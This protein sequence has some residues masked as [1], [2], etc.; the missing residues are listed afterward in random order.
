MTRF[1]RRSP[2][3]VLPGVSADAWRKFAAALETRSVSAVSSTGGLGAYEIHPRRLVEL[4]KADNLRY[5]G[6]SGRVQVCDFIAP[7][8]RERFLADPQLQ[9]S[10]FARSIALYNQQLRAGELQQPEGATKAETLAALHIGGR[11]ALKDWAN[12]FERTRMLCRAVRE[13]F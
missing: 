11:G 1:A 7:L 12:L 2:L 13:I 3:I 9:Y 6:G 10:L 4:K 8:T 5:E